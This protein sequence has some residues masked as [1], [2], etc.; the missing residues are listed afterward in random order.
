MILLQWSGFVGGPL[1]W[2]QPRLLAGFDAG[3][4]G[5]AAVAEAIRLVAGLHNVAVMREA[6]EQRRGHLRIDKDAG[7]FGEDEVCRDDHAGVF[8]ELREQVK[9]KRS[10]DSVLRDA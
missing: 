10:T 2:F 6:I 7:P 4:G 1:L 8:I 3:F 9:R 5:M